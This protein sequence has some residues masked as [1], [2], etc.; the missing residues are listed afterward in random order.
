MSRDD[1]DR[2]SDFERALGKGVKRMPKDAAP[3]PR[4]Q[5][6]VRVHS[7]EPP[8]DFEIVS[9]GET[10]AGVARGVDHAHLR[11]LRSGQYRPELEIDLHGMHAAEAR[12]ELRGALAH[13]SDHGLRCLLVIH[14][15]G[16]HSEAEAVLKNSLVGW[17]AE[18]PH[19][20]RVLAWHSGVRGQG[21]ATYVLLRRPGR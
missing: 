7:E 13:A 20:R 21:G 2:P 14:G 6:P 15:R 10:L 8:A 9:E 1:D 5:P 3:P 4:K 19:G 17:L 16:K 18:P 12:H 11:K